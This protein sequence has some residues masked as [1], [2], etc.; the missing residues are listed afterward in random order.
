M[1]YVWVVRTV[2]ILYPSS[3]PAAKGMG[4]MNGQSRQP[5]RAV[6]TIGRLSRTPSED[7]VLAHLPGFDQQESA[8]QDQAIAHSWVAAPLFRT[9]RSDR[10]SRI[11]SRSS[12]ESS[13]RSY[14]HH[15]IRVIASVLDTIDRAVSGQ[16]RP[17][18]TFDPP[19][20]SLE[21]LHEAIN[22][23]ERSGELPA[24]NADLAR[25]RSRAYAETVAR[26]SALVDLFKLNHLS[27]AELLGKRLAIAAEAERLSLISTT[28]SR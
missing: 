8:L 21:A 16:S 7:V 23:L 22:D 14:E 20:M 11:D 25:R 15:Q 9:A 4:Y 28:R 5:K 19:P 27:A 18:A 10:V 13:I 3:T 1:M 2:L 24:A 12:L 17:V 6:R 26:L